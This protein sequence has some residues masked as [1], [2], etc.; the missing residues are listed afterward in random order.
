MDNQT[1]I[2]NRKRRLLWFL[3]LGV[4]LAGGYTVLL[5][6][7]LWLPQRKWDMTAYKKI[8]PGMTEEEVTECLGGPAA[9][10]RAT[11]TFPPLPGFGKAVVKPKYWVF[12][13]GIV[14][15]N[16]DA[17]GKV[18]FWNIFFWSSHPKASPW[19]RLMN[20]LGL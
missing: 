6:L 18:T 5:Y 1:V 11:E 20:T 13:A 9:G 14:E 7:P 4:A 12:D 8:S 3:L 10:S 19:R 16:F 15:V 2:G 17:S